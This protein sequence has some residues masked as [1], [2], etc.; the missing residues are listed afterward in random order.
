MKGEDPHAILVPCDWQYPLEKICVGGVVNPAYKQFNNWG[1]GNV[2]S[3]NWYYYPEA[4]KVYT[5]SVFK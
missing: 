3:T 2:A 1:Q 4:G 5:Q